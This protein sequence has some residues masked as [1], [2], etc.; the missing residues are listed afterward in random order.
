MEKLDILGRDEFVDNL[1]RLI[2]NI[3]DNKS[4]CC[5]ALNGAWGC[6]KSFVLDMLE[7]R[8][9]PIQSEETNT[10]RYFVIRYNCW[11][12][13]YYE[14][15]IVAIVAA[16]LKAIE[17]KINLLDDCEEKS[18]I[19]GMLKA[20]TTEFLSIANDAI[21]EKYG[22]NIKA[23]VDAV[24]KGAENGTDKYIKDHAYD[25]YFS[26]NEAMSKLVKLIYDLSDSYTV[27]FI[28]DELD[29]CIPEYGIKVLE[30]LHH[31]TESGSNIISVVAVDK[32][33]LIKSVGHLFG[34]DEFDSQRYLEKFFNFEVALDYG[35]ISEKITEKYS[36]YFSN[37]DK[38]MLKFEEPIGE[39]LGVIFYEFDIRK[40]E[41]IVNRAAIAH[42][43]LFTEKKSYV[44][45]CMELLITVMICEKGVNYPVTDSELRGSS[46]DEMF[47][48]VKNHEGEMPRLSY[49]LHTY[50]KDGKIRSEHVFSEDPTTYYVPE[51]CLIGHIAYIWYLMHS[52]NCQFRMLLMNSREYNVTKGIITELK[53][54]AETIRMIK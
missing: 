4:N 9:N 8:L 7:E 5:F 11:K 22:I 10:D 30:R 25:N 41:H 39:V 42:K 17:R 40:Q 29:R 49:L 20:A 14:E 21:S 45:M 18:R 54:F 23:V 52:E 31:I 33:K 13:D 50:I 48:L 46:P 53:K 43:L 36:E 38:D 16:L 26:L 15:P 6:G 47:S 12:Y 51:K 2:E 28:V 44:F 32:E 27:V 1:F 37:F 19:I 34:F 24:L 35:T 3:S